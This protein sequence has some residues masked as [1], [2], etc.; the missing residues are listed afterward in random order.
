[1]P[2]M[3][4]CSPEKLAASLRSDPEL[5]LAWRA[6]SLG[7]VWLAG[8]WI[9]DR[10]LGRHPPDLDLVAA[11]PAQRVAE[12]AGRLA[13]SLGARP[14]LVGQPPRSVWRIDG[15][16][17]AEILVLGEPTPEAEALRRDFTVNA[18]LWR[19]PDGPLV[20][21]AGGLDDVSRRRL[22]A[23]SRR[24]LVVDPVR[25]LRGARLAATLSAFTLG[26][27]TR[28][29]MAELAPALATAPRER[30]G[31][32]WLTISAC[33]DPWPALRAGLD[34]GLVAGSAPRVNQVRDDGTILRDSAARLAGASPH[35][36]PSAVAQAG[37]AAVLSWLLW[38]WGHPS[39]RD[40]QALAWPGDLAA[41]A[42]TAAQAVSACRRAV[43][44]AAPDRRELL[45]DLGSAA[46]A[47]LAVAGAVDGLARRTAWQRWWRLWRNHQRMLLDPPDVLPAKEVMALLGLAPGPTLG[48]ALQAVRRAMIR[49]EIR[50]PGGARRWLAR[51]EFG[52]G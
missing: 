39:R 7:E 8:G 2:M 44:G 28:A 37:P 26:D 6:L 49:G 13:T 19:L 3:A 20:D 29:W 45:A 31:Q 40:V 51:R 27:E 5:R 21:P 22:R 11:G 9:R 50:T 47:A 35:P 18:M 46:P 43:D 41:K 10:A 15:R 48:A 17:K 42:R 4:A 36:V 30:V 16:L 52:S 14:H 34:L 24:N 12:A 32:E 38:A 1:M 25:L 33:G 23:V